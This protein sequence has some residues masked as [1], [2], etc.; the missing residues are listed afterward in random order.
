[1]VLYVFW[2]SNPPTVV[3]KCKFRHLTLAHDS[4]LERPWSHH[5]RRPVFAKRWLWSGNL[6]APGAKFGLFIQPKTKTN[7]CHEAHLYQYEY[8]LFQSNNTGKICNICTLGNLVCSQV[9]LKMSPVFPSLGHHC[10]NHGRHDP[11]WTLATSQVIL[12]LCT[13]QPWYKWTADEPA[14]FEDK[15]HHYPTICWGVFGSLS[16]L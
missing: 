15:Q 13:T 1:M 12:L 9:A 10:R 16:I 4:D 11:H 8:Y 7:T 3:K 5:S 2:Q 6:E 14:Q